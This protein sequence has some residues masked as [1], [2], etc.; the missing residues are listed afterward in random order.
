MEPELD[1]PH[2]GSD[3]HDILEEFS[4]SQT[5]LSRRT[6]IPAS[7]ISELLHGRRSVTPEYSLRL[8]RFFRQ[9]DA[10]WLNM[11]REYDLRRVRREKGKLIEREVTPVAAAPL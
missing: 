10:F 11:Q 9:D 3:L 7:R 4:L 8:G 6:G 5:E 2:P 1:Y